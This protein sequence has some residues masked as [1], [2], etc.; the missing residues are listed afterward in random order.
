MWF[1]S[2]D[3]DG[4]VF[5]E[6][7]TPIPIQA[8]A[9]ALTVVRIEAALYHLFRD[10]WRVFSAIIRSSAALANG[11][12]AHTKRQIGMKIATKLLTSRIF[13]RLPISVTMNL[14]MVKNPFQ[15]YNTTSSGRHGMFYFRLPCALFLCTS[16]YKYTRGCPNWSCNGIRKAP[17][18]L[19]QRRDIISHL[20]HHICI[21]SRSLDIDRWH[22]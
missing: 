6:H 5:F 2:K 12:M 3:G 7:F 10:F 13:G 4:I 20:T 11:Q 18:W 22:K 8:I 16:H 19:S 14:L 21:S 15:I 17:T 9:L 1:Q